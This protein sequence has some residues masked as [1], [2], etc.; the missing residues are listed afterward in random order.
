MFEV[1]T[2]TFSSRCNLVIRFW[3]SPFFSDSIDWSLSSWAGSALEPWSCI[4]VAIWTCTTYEQSCG[5]LSCTLTLSW[6]EASC[7]PHNTEYLHALQLLF[8]EGVLFL[9][10]L[11]LDLHADELSLHLST[12]ILQLQHRDTHTDNYIKTT[13]I[14]ITVWERWQLL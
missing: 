12:L 10:R 8:G 9:Q 14:F 6:P 5:H 3:I 2:S 4:R 1:L 11:V 7:Y 13:V